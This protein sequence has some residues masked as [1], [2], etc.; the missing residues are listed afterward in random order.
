VTEISD[1][2]LKPITARQ[3]IYLA[4]LRLDCAI[5]GLNATPDV[6]S[7]IVDQLTGASDLLRMVLAAQKREE[8][9]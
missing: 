2:T 8:D 4:E 3:A 9:A 6:S 5:A 7:F 1:P